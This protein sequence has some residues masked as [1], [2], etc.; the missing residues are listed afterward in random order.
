MPSAVTSRS[1]RRSSACCRRP[2]IAPAPASRAGTRCAWTRCISSAL[3]PSSR[4]R[5][6]ATHRPH[7]PRSS[8]GRSRS[9]CAGR[10]RSAIARPRSSGSAQEIERQRAETLNAARN[11]ARELLSKAQADA[12]RELQEAEARGAR[13]LEQSRHQAT[14]LTNAARAEVEQTLEWARN[15]ARRRHRPRA[16]GRRAAS[17]RGRART[18]RDRRGRGR[19]HALRGAV[20]RGPPASADGRARRPANERRGAA[21]ARGLGAVRAATVTFCT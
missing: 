11:E 14:E 3:R 4:T 18:G 2:A 5:S 21:R 13:L 7:P 20:E 6:S 1:C 16:A 10:A 12:A 19:D 17:R 15:Q 8:R 9:S